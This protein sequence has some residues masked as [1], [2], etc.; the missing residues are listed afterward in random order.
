VIGS[1][2]PA[3]EPAATASVGARS[4]HACAGAATAIAVHVAL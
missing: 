1:R 2:V 4:I 3:A